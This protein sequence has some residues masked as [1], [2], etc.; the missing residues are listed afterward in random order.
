MTDKKRAD[1]GP[2]AQRDAAKEALRAKALKANLRRRKAPPPDA[3]T[4]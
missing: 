2:T 4:P 3:N 1:G